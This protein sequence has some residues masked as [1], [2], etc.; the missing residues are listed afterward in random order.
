MF[1]T[2]HSEEAK[3]MISDRLSE[4]RNGVGIFDL[5]NNLIK[6]FKNNV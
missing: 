5:K 3:K 6:N 1:F 4:H 2:K